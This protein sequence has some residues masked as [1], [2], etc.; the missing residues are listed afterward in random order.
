MCIRDR[1]QGAR[2]AVVESN[3][4]IEKLMG[5]PYPWS[6]KRRIRS[7]VGHLSNEDCGHLLA[8]LDVYKRQGQGDWE[9]GRGAAMD[10]WNSSVDGRICFYRGRVGAQ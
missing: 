8:E 4:D 9:N 3:H 5:G 6:L 10:H 7:N 2:I 1:F